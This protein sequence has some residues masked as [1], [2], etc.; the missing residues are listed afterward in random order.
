MPLN[1]SAST[2][3]LLGAIQTRVLIDNNDRVD[4]WYPGWGKYRALPS[5]DHRCEARPNW[6]YV[7]YDAHTGQ[8]VHTGRGRVPEDPAEK[9]R[10]RRRP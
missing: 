10:K 3:V 1:P 7:I 5:W 6:E 9:A 2:V 4:T 8:K